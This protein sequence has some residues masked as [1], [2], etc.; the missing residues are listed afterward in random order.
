MTRSRLGRAALIAIVL[1]A[2]LGAGI[3]Q[4]AT[5]RYVAT[6]AH[7]G[8]N[9][10][11]SN[12]CN[13]RA[14]PCLTVGQAVSKASSGDTILIGP[15]RF[16]ESVKTLT[17]KLTFIGAGAGTSTSFNPAKQT[18]VDAVGTH[19]PGFSTGNHATTIK[20]LRIRGG[21]ALGVVWE[22]IGAGGGS[23]HPSLTVSGS[24]L[25]QSA[26]ISGGMDVPAL[27]AIGGAKVSGLEIGDRRSDRWR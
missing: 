20:S 9:N 1:Q 19:F 8:N 4:A 3:A 5:D 6:A 16:P 11:G 23:S 24:V 13:N 15:G 22:A 25:L 18:F 7:D 26:P 17:K 10:G 27:D 2:G 21:G 14:A 12:T